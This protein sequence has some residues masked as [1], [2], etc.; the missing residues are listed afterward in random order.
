MLGAIGDAG[1]Y[2]FNYYKNITAG[3]GGMFV[4]DDYRAYQRGSITI[5]CCRFY[6][7]GRDPALKPF[8]A[9]GSRASEVSGAILNVQLGRLPAMIGKMREQKKRILRETSETGLKPIRANDL[10]GECGSYVMYT[11][12]EARQAEA[13]AKRMGGFV[14]AKTGRHVYTEWD[15]IFDHRGAHHPA[16]NPFNLKENK[17]LR[18]HYTKGMCAR[19]LDIL[20]RTAAFGTHPAY[21][22]AEVGQIIRKARRAAREVL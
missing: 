16:L 15:P 21:T 1:A 6:W 3:E 13:F 7:D 9:N 4:T 11:F 19:S 14:T 2:S 20:N 18:M 5:D 12:E 10:G 8:T 17:G 22:A